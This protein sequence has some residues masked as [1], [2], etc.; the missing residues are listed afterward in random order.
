M[1]SAPDLF[2]ATDVRAMERALELAARGLETTDPNPRVGCVLQQD[3]EIVGEGWH[4]RAGEA[5]AE[6]RALEAA[7][8]RAR[9]A[10]AYVTLEPCSHFGRTPPCTDALIDAG[11]AR[12]IFATED[13]NPEVHGRGAERLRSAGIRVDQGPCAEAAEELNI[14]FFKRMRTGLPFVRLKLAMSLDG[15]TAL[16]NGESRWITGDEA[17]ADVQRWRARSSAVLTGIGTVLADDPRLDVRS[18][19][20]ARQPMRVVLDSRGRM[21]SSARLF[22]SRGQVLTFGAATSTD[23]GDLSAVLAALGRLKC[24]EVLVEAGA[25]LA[26]SF[27]R[28]GLVDEL[29]LY[30]APIFLGPQARALADLPPLDALSAAPRFALRDTRQIGPDLRIILRRAAAAT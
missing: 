23:P 14:G 10:T 8:S 18:T 28:D 19:P 2:D 11:V 12:V 30:V 25:R 26:G 15:R 7:G 9:G 6:V 22:E 17:R 29:I 13:P 20:D 4:A 21:P 27:I 24:N 16:A 5:H 3:G 1:S